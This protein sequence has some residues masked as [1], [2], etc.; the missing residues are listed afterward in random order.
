MCDKALLL[1]QLGPVQSF[2]AQAETLG[3]LKAGSYLLS[4]LT[5]AALRSID[6][7]A[8]E[9]IF[10]D[11]K[12]NPNLEGIPNR[13]LVYVD[14]ARAREIAAAA[15]DAARDALA[16]LAEKACEKVE[17]KIAFLQQ[18]NAFLQMTWVILTDLKENMG[19]NYKAIGRLM[20]L[21]RNTREFDQWQECGGKKKD[22]LSGKENALDPK[23]GLGA[24]NLMKRYLIHTREM[25]TPN[26]DAYFAIIAMDGDRMGEGLSQFKTREEHLNFSHQLYLFS[27]QVKEISK[28]FN[29]T[30]I[31]AGGDDVLAVISAK[32][33]FKY[34][35]ALREAF[36]SKVCGKTASAGIAVAHRSTPLQDVVHAAHAA[37]S[38]AKN[39]YGRDALAVTIY[40]RSGETLEW[41]CKWSSVALKLYDALT[42][43]SEQLATFAYKLSR[44]LMPYALKGSLPE[45]MDAVLCADTLHALEQTQAARKALSEAD[46]MAYL[47]EASVKANAEDFLN[48]FLCETF[49]NRPR[50]VEEVK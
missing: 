12:K 32:D 6:A 14:K 26:L 50:E 45:G 17:N 27:Q 5:A 30:L 25:K 8:E 37:E 15:E 7:Y 43:K 29:A 9:T 34:A 18:V 1:F 31:Y 42:A 3:D 39:K 40:K 11:V 24:M 38:R 44:F 2:I 41:G 35:A 36:A 21:R 46:V 22:F 23:T 33:A 13:F 20:A 4:L 10:P 48:F 28:D 16:Q 47:C 19:E 49:I